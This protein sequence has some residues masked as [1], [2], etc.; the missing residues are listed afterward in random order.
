MI[1]GRP[2]TLREKI[3][4]YRDIDGGM[5]SYPLAFKHGINI[6]TAIAMRSNP[7][8]AY[9]IEAMKPRIVPKPHVMPGITMEQLM[10]GKA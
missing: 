2:L 9:I 6:Q 8:P 3:A 10:A 4:V 5:T 1:D 7:R